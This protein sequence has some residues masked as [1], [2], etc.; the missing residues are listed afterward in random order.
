MHR[1]L[2]ARIIARGRG[3]WKWY[4]KRHSGWHSGWH[5]I[6]RRQASVLS[7]TAGEGEH[8][9]TTIMRHRVSHHTAMS[10]RTPSSSIFAPSPLAT[11]SPR[12]IT[13]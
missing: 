2:D 1:A 6:G 13:T 4:S 5:S 11:T 10:S 8:T 9:S 7:R 12:L 3:H